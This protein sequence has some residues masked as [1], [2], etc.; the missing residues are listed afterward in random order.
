MT[1]VRCL[2]PFSRCLRLFTLLLIACIGI[3][4]LHAADPPLSIPKAEPKESE[5]AG[6]VD[7]D[8]DLDALLDAKNVFPPESGINDG[9]WQLT[10][11]PGRILVRVPLK[12]T[13]KD[14]TVD[15]AEVRVRLRG[16]RFL[17]WH[18]VDDDADNAAAAPDALATE[19]NPVGD[20]ALP[21]NVPRFAKTIKVTKDGLVS[22]ELDR[23][24]F[25]A[26]V[27]GGEGWYK[28]K[29]D[30]K[31]LEALS[32]GSAPRLIRED[33][34]SPADFQRRK[35]AAEAEWR[36]K[37]LEY[38]EITK[39]VLKLPEEFK[40]P[41]PRTLWA[42]YETRAN[43]RTLDFDGPEPMPWEFPMELLQALQSAARP[44]RR[45]ERSS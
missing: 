39:V 24:I 10:A 30:R 35:V 27:M 22:W 19:I 43:L 3:A 44:P 45:R 12:A 21:V 31:A 23:V 17:A 1:H 20:K 42:V 7:V 33:G 41:A 34:E 38:R 13:V 29:L 28:L 26:T 37:A 14:G 6:E 32:P 9:I 11:G 15:L 5:A 18:L 16:G 25:N 2:V 4:Q 36:K 8:I 40:G